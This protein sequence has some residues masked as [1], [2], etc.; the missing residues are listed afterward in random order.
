MKQFG[1]YSRFRGKRSQISFTDK[2]R[3]HVGVRIDGTMQ[4]VYRVE[5]VNLPPTKGKP[6]YEVHVSDM[7]DEGGWFQPTV[8]KRR[9]KLPLVTIRALAE[10]Y[11]RRAREVLCA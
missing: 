5:L 1:H 6:G 4:E 3:A 11:E 2:Y 9:T 7:L 10:K 8:E